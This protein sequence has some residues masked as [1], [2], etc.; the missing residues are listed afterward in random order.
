MA[1]ELLCVSLPIELTN[2]NEG[3]KKSWYRPADR[4]RSYEKT[5]RYMG[6][7]RTPFEVPVVV[8]VTRVLGRGQQ[9]WDPD[10][11]LRGN[12]KEL[13]DAL[14]ACG[15]FE[16][17]SLEFIKEVRGIQDA[18]QRGNGPSVIVSVSE[19]IA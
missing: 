17:D 15:W 8:L 6:H 1:K 13:I 9:F 10:S 11:I 19:A 7:E 5:I 3:R 12:S 4:R 18:S 16:D 2:G 14:V